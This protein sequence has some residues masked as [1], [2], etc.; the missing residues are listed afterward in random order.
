MSSFRLS[1]LFSQPEILRGID[2]E[3]LLSLLAGHEAALETLAIVAYRQPILRADIEAIRG[4]DVLLYDAQYTPDEYLDGRVGWGHS[5]Y[6]A[7]VGIAREAGVKKLVLFHHEPP[8]TTRCLP[9][10]GPFG[11]LLGELE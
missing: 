7:A 3:N 8:R 5:T 4:A 10:D 9:E 11:L 6:E 1:R 2:P